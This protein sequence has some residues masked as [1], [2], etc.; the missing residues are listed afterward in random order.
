MPH[1]TSGSFP[2]R[3]RLLLPAQLCWQRIKE[4]GL[5]CMGARSRDPASRRPQLG[6]DGQDFWATRRCLNKALIDLVLPNSQI[7]PIW[8]CA[9]GYGHLV[10]DPRAAGYTVT[11][12]D[13]KPRNDEVER[14]DFFRDVLY[15]ASPS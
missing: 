11:A 5:H 9:A 6:Q 12:N 7:K 2:Q 4:S 15:E 13:A 8:E 14:R 1:S 10:Q 3:C